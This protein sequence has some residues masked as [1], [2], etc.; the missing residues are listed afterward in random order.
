[1]NNE[2]LVEALKTEC[3]MILNILENNSVEKLVDREYYCYR[4]PEAIEL[5]NRMA[6][7]RKDTIKLQKII[8][9]R[10]EY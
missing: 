2:L 5:C 4:S 3:K 10:S 6:Q 1:M 7:L 8:Y 9:P